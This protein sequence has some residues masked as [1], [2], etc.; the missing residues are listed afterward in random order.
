MQKPKYKTPTAKFIQFDNRDIII[1]SPG[2]LAKCL[3]ALD[4]TSS[5]YPNGDS[6]LPNRC[7]L[8]GYIDCETFAQRWNPPKCDTSGNSYYVNSIGPTDI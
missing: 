7:I 5:C 6:S 4:G 2:D 8:A 3:S 1:A